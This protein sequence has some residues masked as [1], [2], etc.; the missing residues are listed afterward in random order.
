MT[1]CKVLWLSPKSLAGENP[2]QIWSRYVKERGNFDITYNKNDDYDIVFFSSDSV[3]DD[4]IID[5]DHY[6]IVY[7]WDFLS[8]R[9]IHPEYMKGVQKQVARMKRCDLI[10]VPTQVTRSQAFTLGIPATICYPGIDDKMIDSTPEQKKEYQICSIGRLERYKQFDWTIIAASTITPKP[11]VVIIG[12]GSDKE[13]LE[14][15]ARDLGVVCK[16]WA[17]SD[18]DKFIEMR[19]SVCFVSPTLNEGF[20]MPVLEAA[21]CGVPVLAMDTPTHREILK[22]F[23]IYFNT[24]SG[25]AQNIAR[26]INNKQPYEMLVNDGREYV[27]DNLTFTLAAARMDAYFNYAFGQVLGQKLKTDD[28]TEIYDFDHKRKESFEKECFDPHWNRHWRVKH[29]LKALK[30]K[31]VLD[32]GCSHGVYSVRLAEKGFYVTAVDFS[33][34]ALEQCKN[35]IKKYKVEDKVK[36]INAN[37]E[38]L[39]FDDGQYDSCWIGEIFEHVKEP[40]KV[41]SEAIRVTKDGGRIVFSIPLRTHHDSTLH[42]HHWDINGFKK[43]VLE[44]FDDK[45]KITELKLIAEKDR[46]PSIIFGVLEKNGMD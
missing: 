2:Q 27:E 31:N 20:D 6:T 16:I 19:K 1:L 39:P 40:T 10:L 45:I 42:L 29:V 38:E 17:P 41:L 25:L 7:F 15:L 23:A 28:M 24:I 3:L 22:E 46:E 13:R 18:E 5:S 34:V 26:L 33:D 12:T 11:K 43:D 35:T 8:P 4:E 21:Y 37:A 9:L 32:I 30:G 14:R 44:P 36:P